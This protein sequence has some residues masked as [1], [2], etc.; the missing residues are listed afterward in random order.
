MSLLSVRNIG[1][2]FRTYHS[3][4][5]RF[6]RWFGLSIKPSEEHWV[7]RHADFDVYPSDAIGIIGKNG[8][9]KSTLL[10]II[11][12]T[13]K[14]TEGQVIANGRIAAILELG[15]GFNLELTGR[16][17]VR[18]TAGLMGLT[19]EQIEQA[20][21]NIVAFADI[22]E[23]FDEPM[24]IYSSGMHARVAF[25]V[26]TAFR[27]EVLIIDEALSVGDAAFQR[28]CF[29]K[30]EV[31][32]AKGTALL[33][34]SHDVETI[35]KTCNKAL[36][37]DSGKIVDFGDT[38][39]VCDKYERILFGAKK[40]EVKKNIEVSLAG[41][42]KSLTAQ[43]E[44]SYGNN[45]AQIH[46]CWIQG[47]NNEKVNIVETG[48]QLIWCFDVTFNVDVSQPYYNMQVKT[49]EGIVLFGVNSDFLNYKSK[50][51]LAGTVVKIKFNFVNH[52]AP[53]IYFLNC[54]VK[55]LNH[56]NDEKFLHRRVDAAILKVIAS[57]GSSASR[58]IVDLD[59]KLSILLCDESGN[60]I[61]VF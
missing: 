24:R 42:D 36:Y 17:N 60:E 14:P 9:G 40:L 47:E 34:V 61:D 56:K 57:D 27:P 49:N 54:G 33:L 44:T 51:V 23:Y 22:G 48:S 50:P 12:G 32:Q 59:A 8:A 25:S 45:K 29:R 38:K 6:A 30:I 7:L 4:W 26:A 15:M 13:L 5:Q 37:I 20:M 11:T 28:K 58:G 1:K 18:H 21:P 19:A 3:E 16:Q 55:E 2:S 46:D 53:G 43:S 10:K 31:F 52:L 35:K 41:Y 39:I